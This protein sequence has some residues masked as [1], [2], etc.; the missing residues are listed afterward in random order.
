MSP[1]VA[2]HALEATREL[3]L[4][5]VDLLEGLGDVIGE[6]LQLVADIRQSGLHLLVEVLRLVHVAAPLLAIA[7]SLAQLQAASHALHLEHPLLSA[8]LR[9]QD[10]LLKHVVV[11][12]AAALASTDVEV[13]IDIIATVFF[14]L[15]N[16]ISHIILPLKLVTQFISIVVSAE[17]TI[18][19]DDRPLELNTTLHTS[20]AQHVQDGANTLAEARR[21]LGRRDIDGQAELSELI[22]DVGGAIK[23]VVIL[24]PASNLVIINREQPGNERHKV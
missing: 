24:V 1:V 14:G 21:Q 8:D 15:A 11:V 9:V 17:A 23:R 18:I 7:G 2:G 13:I 16:N 5:L 10:L 20:H 4:L 6:F 3:R 12:V 19:S 22:N